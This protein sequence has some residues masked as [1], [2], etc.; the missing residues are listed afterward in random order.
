LTRA[1]RESRPSDAHPAADNVRAVSQVE[2][3][4]LRRRSPIEWI[5]DAIAR[6]AAGTPSLVVHAVFFGGWLAINT[7]RVPGLEA[8]DPF[9]FGLLTTIVSLEAI[10]LSL[11]ILVSQN[12]MSRQAE[13]REHLDLQ[14]NL[15]A[16]QESTA[17]LKLLR[18]LCEHQGV[19]LRAFDEDEEHLEQKTSVQSLVAEIDHRLPT[20]S[21]PK[22]SG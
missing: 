21:T 7:H 22:P 4:E 19:D 1:A 16:E 11:F 18:R 10:F 20:G 17:T 5:A 14:I 15:L 3:K 6:A 8:F 12:R 13:R 9:P 2:E